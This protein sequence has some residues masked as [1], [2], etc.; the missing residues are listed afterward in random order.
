MAKKVPDRHGS[1]AE[2]AAELADYLRGTISSPRP[3]EAQPAAPDRES[4]NDTQRISQN[5]KS[6][7]RSRPEVQAERA[8]PPAPRSI[9]LRRKRKK[10]R[11]SFASGW[12]WLGAGV[13]AVMVALLVGLV[14][15]H[16][17]HGTIKTEVGSAAGRKDDH[18]VRRD[19]EP[20]TPEP[21]DLERMQG[22]WAVAVLI[23][24]GV[25]AS[26]VTLETA[27]V[28]ISGTTMTLT[29]LGPEQK[30]TFKLDTTQTPRQFDTQFLSG[31]GRGQME[32]GIY[33][34]ADG[35]LRICFAS[36]EKPVRPTTF[37]SN[38]ENKQEL[39]VLERELGPMP[40]R[41]EPSL[42]PGLLWRINWPGSHLYHTA[43]SPLGLH[44][45]AGGDT[46]TL[47]IWEV[48]TGRP[49]GELPIVTGLFTPDG[50]QV[51]GHKGKTIVYVYDLLGRRVRSLNLGKAIA[52][53]AISP[54]GKLIACGHADRT[55]RLW[56]FATAEEVR[57]FE[58]HTGTADVRFSPS[59]KYLLS[60]SSAD[61]SVRLWDV[62]SGKQIRV[63][64]DFKDVTA[65][66][67]ND[68]I[69]QAF[70]AGE[71]RLGG[72]VWGKK[73]TF[74]LWDA[75]TGKRIGQLDLG[76]DFHK[77]LAVSADGRWLLTGHDD[78]TV[79]LR[80]VKSGKELHRFQMADINV[81]R[82]LSFSPDGRYAVA[83][84]HRSWVYLWQLKR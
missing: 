65:I 46:G 82:G 72:Y 63:F 67:G 14:L 62:D 59:G 69:L 81:P 35:R 12:L 26:P 64:D 77:D 68:L 80:D 11:G 73:K 83:G 47:R 30:T 54:D 48:S 13:G 29:G 32:P 76:A 27:R 37:I 38:L 42:S 9:R 45:L 19:R 21:T 60:A 22:E 7:V 8:E 10:K 57:A 18:G 84:S 6:G 33:E 70:F 3:S 15:R 28:R 43:F 53:L 66:P 74:L 55:I 5:L 2:L 58:G 51:V 44:F 20:G 56:N 52:S 23:G 71:G 25:S 16:A 40:Q 41:P 75:A 79:R 4:E 17:R 31:P 24:R 50:L 49:I 39:I 34:F 1:M 78:R 61:R 36:L